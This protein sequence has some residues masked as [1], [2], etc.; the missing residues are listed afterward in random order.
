MPSASG[1][2][3][4]E[5]FVEHEAGPVVA[6][7]ARLEHEQHPPGELVAAGGE[8]LGRADQHRRVGVVAAGVHRVVDG[9]REVEARV[10][11]HRQGVH[12]APQEDRRPGRVP[13]SRAA[14]PLVVSWTVTSSGNPSSAASTCSRVSGSSLPTSGQRC[15]LRRSATAGASRSLASSR[16]DRASSVV[17]SRHRGHRTLGART[18][19]P[20]P[21]PVTPR[22]G[23]RPGRRGGRGQS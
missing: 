14:M 21:D 5:P 13:V 15:R 9:G 1:G 8:Q 11:G 22:V 17:S 23:S 20:F 16:T 19:F 12:V 6:L 7:L 18:G 2:H 4:E 10:L 3:V